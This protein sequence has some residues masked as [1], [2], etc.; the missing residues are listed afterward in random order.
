MSGPVLMRLSPRLWL[1]GL[2]GLALLLAAVLAAEIAL[3]PSGEPM[4]PQALPPPAGKA[5]T[6]GA[7]AA[8]PVPAW[9][10]SILA[11]PLFNEDRRP[12]AA[13]VAASG[14]AAV[15]L[16]RL[17]GVLVTSTGRRAIFAAPEGGRPFTVPEGGRIGAFTVSRIADGAVTVTGPDGVR[18]LRPSFAT[19]PEAAAIASQPG[20]QPGAD[21]PAPPSGASPSG[22]DLIRR[23]T[24]YPIPAA[25]RP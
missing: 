25:P 19:G 17:A 18:V 2:V 24:N 21:N 8:D 13:E 11:R 15:G 1:S 22:L 20:P 12:V 10:A 9:V 16:P 7:A 4:L 3:G 6:A 23:S 5:A 14:R